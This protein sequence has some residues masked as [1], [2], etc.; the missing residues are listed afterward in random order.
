MLPCQS[1]FQRRFALVLRDEI[2]Q[3]NDTMH[4]LS[5]NR[6]VREIFNQLRWL[7]IEKCV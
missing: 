3:W 5:N 7:I 4:W 6:A 1:T 2:T